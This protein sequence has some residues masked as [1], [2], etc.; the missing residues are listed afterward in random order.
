MSLQ[1][2]SRREFQQMIQ[3]SA[4]PVVIDFTCEHSAP[5]ELLSPILETMSRDAAGRIGFYQINVERERELARKLSV[6]S[7]PTVMLYADGELVTKSVGYKP[8]DVLQDI[9]YSELP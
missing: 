5:C 1:P 7:I 6:T 3:T 9:L 2:L 4:R 8:K